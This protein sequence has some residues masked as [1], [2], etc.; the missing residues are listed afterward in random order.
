MGT[1]SDHDLH[2]EA[3]LQPAVDHLRATSRAALDDPA[4]LAEALEA[5][6][7][8]VTRHIAD[9]EDSLLREIERRAP[10]L[11]HRTLQLRAEHDEM[12]QLL[13]EMVVPTS[14]AELARVRRQIDVLVR[15]VDRHGDH[16]TDVL[17]QAYNTDLGSGP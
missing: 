9:V 4:A 11:I 2:T 12:Y 3:V 14:E 13:D 1:T 8:A 15:L 10:R 7:T 17:F 5:A 6:R 16:S